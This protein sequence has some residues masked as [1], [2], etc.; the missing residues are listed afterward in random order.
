MPNHLKN[1]RQEKH[2][3]MQCKTIKSKI[4]DFLDQSKENS[5]KS[6][7]KAFTPFIYFFNSDFVLCSR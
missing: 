5:K 1:K 2:E 3:I 6:S 7:K 4:K